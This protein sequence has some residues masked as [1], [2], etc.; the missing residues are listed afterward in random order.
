MSDRHGQREDA[1]SD[2]DGDALEGAAAVLFQVEL[3]FEG[4]VHRLDQL[5]SRF[6]RDCLGAMFPYVPKQTGWNKRLRAALL[7]GP[8]CR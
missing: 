8:A 1:L 3:A 2:A 5:P 6:S 4:V 7:V